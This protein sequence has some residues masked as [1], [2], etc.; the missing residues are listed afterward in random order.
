MAGI[1]FTAAALSRY[2]RIIVSPATAFVKLRD[3]AAVAGRT[4]F[5]GISEFLLSPKAD[6]HRA[7]L[8]LFSLPQL[9]FVVPVS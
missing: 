6:M 9:L 1:D 2:D 5:G 8:E 4:G 7:G 3:G